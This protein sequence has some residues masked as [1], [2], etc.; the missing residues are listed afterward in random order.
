MF[1]PKALCCSLLWGT[2]RPSEPRFGLLRFRGRRLGRCEPP[3]PCSLCLQFRRHPQL[4]A[5]CRDA[6]P[7]GPKC[8][9]SLEE[10]TS[11]G[12]SGRSEVLGIEPSR[13]SDPR[14]PGEPP[15]VAG[16]Q[17]LESEFRWT[18]S[19]PARLSPRIRSSE[20]SL[21]LLIHMA[22]QAP[23]LLKTES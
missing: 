20:I 21:S 10:P 13:R 17:Q 9:P 8:G 18:I 15:L 19:S 14:S 4:P 23:S 7:L 12:E 6:P 22:A 16:Y 1:S 11:P 2:P 5:Q 3:P